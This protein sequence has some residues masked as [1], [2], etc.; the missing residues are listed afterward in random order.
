MLSLQGRILPSLVCEKAMNVTDNLWSCDVRYALHS[1]YSHWKL[2]PAKDIKS[3]VCYV[4][5][6]ISSGNLIFPLCI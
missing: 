5:F 4:E 3:E 2:L 1:E 6:M